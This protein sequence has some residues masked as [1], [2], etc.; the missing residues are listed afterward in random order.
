MARGKSSKRKPPAPRP[1][2]GTLR[3]KRSELAFRRALAERTDQTLQE[4][5][6]QRVREAQAL[7]EQIERKLLPTEPPRWG[8]PRR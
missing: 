3:L 7:R 2:R 4:E 6:A 1:E 8:K 5:L